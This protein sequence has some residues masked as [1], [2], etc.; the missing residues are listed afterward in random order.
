MALL[1]SSNN[2]LLILRKT[3]CSRDV[4][5]LFL[6]PD[7]SSPHKEKMR[8]TKACE[9]G[10]LTRSNAT[11][12]SFGYTASLDL[13][14]C[15]GVS[16]NTPCL[17]QIADV[18]LHFDQ[19]TIGQIRLICGGQVPLYTGCKEAVF[20][21]DSN[22]GSCWSLCGPGSSTIILRSSWVILGCQVLHKGLCCPLQW[23]CLVIEE[24]AK[25]LDPLGRLLLVLHQTVWNQG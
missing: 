25:H 22:R 12:A 18:L 2:F 21:K 4:V 17:T 14:N 8:S 5:A 7:D 19:Q 11:G 23:Q 3:R 1:Q 10:A 6:R 9:A 16:L 20:L 24:P 13:Q 15:N